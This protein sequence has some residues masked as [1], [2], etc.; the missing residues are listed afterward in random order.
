[1]FGAFL[2]AVLT[3]SALLRDTMKDDMRLGE[4]IGRWEE[5]GGRIRETPRERKT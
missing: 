1:M 2:L 5:K 3:H 4:A